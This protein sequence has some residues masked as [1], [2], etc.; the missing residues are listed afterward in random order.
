M[1]GEFK[2]AGIFRFWQN[3]FQFFLPAWKNFGRQ[4]AG[5][6]FFF[7]KITQFFGGTPLKGVGESIFERSF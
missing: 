6:T 4:K 2:Y 1:V 3:K 5:T 7:G